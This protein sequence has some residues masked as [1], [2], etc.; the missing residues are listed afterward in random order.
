MRSS[1]LARS[2]ML[3]SGEGDASGQ[4]A[5]WSVE[6]AALPTAGTCAEREQWAGGAVELDT[7]V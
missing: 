7:Y 4:A 5:A 3:R 6:V 2:L 1:T